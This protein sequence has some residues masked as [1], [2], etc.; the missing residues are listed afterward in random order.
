MTLS[1]WSEQSFP[2]LTSKNYK[3]W[4]IQIK[5]FLIDLELWEAIDEGFEVMLAA[6][7]T[8]KARREARARDKRALS[9]LQR[10]IDGA[11][12]D[13]IVG[14]KSAKPA[15]EILRKAHQSSDEDDELLFGSDVDILE[16]DFVVRG[17]NDDDLRKSTD[18]ADEA[19]KSMHNGAAVVGESNGADVNVVE[20][21]NFYGR[22]SVDASRPVTQANGSLMEAAK[23]LQYIHWTVGNNVVNVVE[24][25]VK[26]E[27][28]VEVVT[29]EEFLVTAEA[30]VVTKKLEMAE[31]KKEEGNAL[32]KAGEYAKASKKYEKGAEYIETVSDEEKNQNKPL[33][34]SCNLNNAACKLKLKDYKQAEKLCTKVLELDSRN[35]K[36]FYRRAQAYIHLVDLELAEIDIRKALEIEPDNREVMLEDKALKDKVKEYNK[37]DAKFYSNMF[38]KLTKL[39]SNDNSAE[40]T[41]VKEDAEAKE[42]TVIAELSS[43]EAEE[44]LEQLEA[45][46]A[47][48]E[49]VSEEK[50]TADAMEDGTYSDKLEDESIKGNEEA[51]LVKDQDNATVVVVIAEYEHS[52]PTGVQ[53]N[54]TAEEDSSSDVTDN[55]GIKASVDPEI[56]K[57]VEEVSLSESQPRRST[58]SRQHV[59]CD[60]F[61]SNDYE[62]L[63]PSRRPK[64]SCDAN[65]DDYCAMEEKLS[66]LP[67]FSKKRGG[68]TESQP[69][70]E[71]VEDYTGRS[72]E[73]DQACSANSSPV[74]APEPDFHEFDDGRRQECFNDDQLWAMYD[75]IDAMPAMSK[76][77][78]YLQGKMPAKKK[79]QMCCLR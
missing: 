75:T 78:T 58:R 79:N 37:K 55:F 10:G 72:M 4:S 68:K 38:S 70:N 20:S 60:E 48:D 64:T 9:I 54:D 74:V 28:E 46:K 73:S 39:E 33:K 61:V 30:E 31:K 14:T 24:D 62:V 16:V 32:F 12:F 36:A 11:N 53:K 6:A 71:C 51:V 19:V 26:T 3:E 56:L 50:G 67:M 34:I 35:V 1:W 66:D 7:V 17:D 49:E 21:D 77:E 23:A 42:T 29:T 13:H 47:E 25:A 44:Q 2:P 59:F 27:A 5:R 45:G 43:E 40:K 22:T 69:G 52:Q 63:N 41:E 15:W 57:A 65:F 76:E 8:E 18:S